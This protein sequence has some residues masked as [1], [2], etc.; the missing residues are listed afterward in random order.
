MVTTA[1]GQLMAG[2]PPFP[3]GSLVNLGNWQDPPYNRWAFQHVRELI[4]TARIRRGDGAA[5]RLPR[6]EGDLSGIRYCSDGR[7]L[8][9]REM[10]AESYTDGFLVLHRGRIVTEQYFNGMR[11]D[12]PHLLMSV[13]KSVVS[14]VAGI[15]AGQGRLEPA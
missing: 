4:P 9:V 11:P 2:A 15:L 8:T 7:E 12:T 13:S 6:A 14:S 5:R 3:A 10:L 1:G